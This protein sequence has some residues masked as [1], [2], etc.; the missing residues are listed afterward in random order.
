MADL[1]CLDLSSAGAVVLQLGRLGENP[2]PPLHMALM[3]GRAVS[4]AHSFVDA[5]VNAQD[6]RRP[7]RVR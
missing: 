7:T 6:S 3:S 4:T 1:V 2:I 5:P